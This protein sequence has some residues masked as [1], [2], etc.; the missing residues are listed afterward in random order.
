MRPVDRRKVPEP[1]ILR[2]NYP[3]TEE[4]ELARAA[5]HMEKNRAL[6]NPKD[7]KAFPF[8]RYKEN[9]V[10]A[11]LER[12]FHGK[13]AYCESYYGGT[14]PVDVEHYRP[15]GEV[16]G[17]KDHEG[18]WWLAMDWDNLLPSC[19]DCNR[20]R[21]QK[22]PD[23][24][25]GSLIR[26]LEDGDFDRSRQ[27]LTGKSSIFPLESEASRAKDPNGQIAAER[28]LLLDPTRDDPRL[29][30]GFF[31]ERDNLVG[32]VY[33]KP[34]AA[35]DAQSP[36][37]LPNRQQVSAMG[38]TS[39][40]VYGLNRLGLVQARTKVLRDL[41]FLLQLI[42]GLSEIAE[43]L[44]GQ[45][46]RRARSRRAGTPSPAEVRDIALSRRILAKIRD[47]QGESVAQMRSMTA[48]EAPYSELA[49]AWL[50]TYL[51]EA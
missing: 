21:Q 48:P 15:K 23:P 32:L 30:L 17:V 2:Q 51:D 39:I 13:C 28:R 26:L 41:E 24:Q 46:E 40:Q 7:R 3:N 11:A 38:M 10:K 27:I 22:T 29:H 14:Q 25:A 16:D 4:N 49:R 45:I 12:L 1:P 6:A 31:V 19:I 34:Q 8:S 47:Y 50:S 5:A 35:E 36:D 44:S 20:R 33:P 9:T 18:Y 42:L 37:V 43:E